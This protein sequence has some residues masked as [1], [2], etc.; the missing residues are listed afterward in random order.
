ME[1]YS[2]GEYIDGEICFR[3]GTAKNVFYDR[4]SDFFTCIGCL[5][6]LTGKDESRG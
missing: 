3:C 6:K 4:K 5:E 1:L 2:D